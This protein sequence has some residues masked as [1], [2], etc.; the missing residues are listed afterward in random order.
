[1]TIGNKGSAG[2]GK[3]FDEGAKNQ[4]KSTGSKIDT[5]QSR[6]YGRRGQVTDL[7]EM[8]RASHRFRG[9]HL[10]SHRLVLDLYSV[11]PKFL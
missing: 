4:P 1:M 8:R 3:P 7:H 6:P 11:I 10:V 2:K 9:Q 5:K